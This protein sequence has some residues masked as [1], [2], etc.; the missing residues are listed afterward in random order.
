MIL[1]WGIQDT[2]LMLSVHPMQ[3]DTQCLHLP[4]ILIS[5][6]TFLSVVMG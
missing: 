3:N 5:A 1:G 6:E 4:D 2:G